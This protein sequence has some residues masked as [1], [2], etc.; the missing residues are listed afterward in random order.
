MTLDLSIG[1]T[2]VRYFMSQHIEEWLGYPADSL[3]DCE[4]FFFAPITGVATTFTHAGGTGLA[5]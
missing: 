3:A 1:A 5:E 4:L 2:S